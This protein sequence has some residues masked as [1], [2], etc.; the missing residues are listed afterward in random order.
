MAVGGKIIVKQE[1]AVPMLCY[2][3]VFVEVFALDVC[4]CVRFGYQEDVRPC[5]ADRA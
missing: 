4:M 5:C 1:M 3:C 2:E